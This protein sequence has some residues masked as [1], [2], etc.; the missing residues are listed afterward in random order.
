[1]DKLVGR[2]LDEIETLGIRSNTY[3]V[4][5]GDNGTWEPD[6]KN[7]K[8]G[9]PG[10]REHTR[11]TTAGNVNGGKDQL[12]D[13]GSHVPLLVWGPRSVPVGSVCHDLVDVVDL[14]PTFCG[15]TG[16][17]PPPALTLD[18]R[19]LVPRL[20]GKPGIPRDWVH[21]ALDKRKGG[22]NLFDG[23][24]RLFRQS[25]RLI[26]ARA[27]PLEKP[28]DPKDPEAEAAKTMLTAIFE[29]IQPDGPRPPVPFV[30]EGK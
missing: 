4:F 20:H 19:S 2:L 26:D 10:E 7:P 13:G 22:E 17:K 1:M 24:F 18:G 8:A 28:A 27:L 16:T 15:L 9:Q 21:H 11:H 29:K 12:N 14:F 3:V 5:M 25:E 6:F 30:T 23:Q